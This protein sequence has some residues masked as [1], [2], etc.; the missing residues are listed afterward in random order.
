M[1]F[2]FLFYLFDK[3]KAVCVC[4]YNWEGEVN[5]CENVLLIYN[6]KISMF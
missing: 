6:L 2:A 3:I 1:K 4:I 5:N